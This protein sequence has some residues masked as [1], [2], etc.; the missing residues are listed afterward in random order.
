M[1]ITSTALQKQKNTYQK[2]SD[3]DISDLCVGFL[4]AFRDAST[5]ETH[6]SVTPEGALSPIH[7][8]ES[9]PI[10][11]VSEWDDEGRA[12]ALRPTIIA[13]FFRGERFFTLDELENKSW[14]A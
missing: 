8:I 6:F 1:L 5:G 13:G 2:L 4:P 3:V 14:D 10:D 9:L 12:V 11:W 7:L